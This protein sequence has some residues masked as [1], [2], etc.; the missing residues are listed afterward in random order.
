MST[1]IIRRT[2]ADGTVKEYRYT[3]KAP[4]KNR[5]D[6]R[7]HAS[8]SKPT[9][10]T[11][12]GIVYFVQSASGFIKI[13]FSTDLERRIK[14]LRIGNPEKLVV[15]AA[16]LAPSRLEWQLH[17]KFSDL[18]ASGEWFFPDDR[19]RIEIGRLRKEFENASPR[20]QDAIDRCFKEA[21]D[22]LRRDMENVFHRTE[23]QALSN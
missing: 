18:A 8:Q 4:S 15:L 1:K 7:A 9:K 6:R 22:F 2:L 11:R 3:R 20:D 16:F 17:R 10:S 13:G 12:T 19:I 5:W 14:Q 23:N 21:A